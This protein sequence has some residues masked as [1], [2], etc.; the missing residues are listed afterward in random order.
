MPTQRSSPRPPWW[1][2]DCRDG[3]PAPGYRSSA[4]PMTRPSVPT[5]VFGELPETIPKNSA[6]PPAAISVDTVGAKLMTAGGLTSGSTP[7]Y[8]AAASANWMPMIRPAMD[9]TASVSRATAVRYQPEMASLTPPRNATPGKSRTMTDVTVSEVSVCAWTVATVA[10]T[11]TATTPAMNCAKN[12]GHPLR[13]NVPCAQ[14]RTMLTT[15]ALM[16]TTRS[17]SAT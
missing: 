4:R 13:V 15:N 2:S 9:V 5:R 1:P 12:S 17:A 11:A 8:N 6:M 3:N 16:V 7:K 10:A 14:A